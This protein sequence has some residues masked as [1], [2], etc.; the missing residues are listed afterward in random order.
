MDVDDGS[1]RRPDRAR[2]IRCIGFRVDSSDGVLGILEEVRDIR[3]G[4]DGE[5]VVRAGKRGALL[6]VVP[7]RDVTSV[8]PT[9]HRVVLRSRFDVVSSEELSACARPAAVPDA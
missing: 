8:L 5:L 3:G 6:L 4:D 2:L 7:T 9:Q 1:G